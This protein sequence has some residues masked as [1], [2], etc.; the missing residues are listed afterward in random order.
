M[1]VAHVSFIKQTLLLLFVHCCLGMK[2]F[3][4]RFSVGG[5]PW[6]SPSLELLDE[7]NDAAIYKAVVNSMNEWTR[8]QSLKKNNAR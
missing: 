7:L 6:A 3:F 2:C 5:S 8:K 1:L 4:F